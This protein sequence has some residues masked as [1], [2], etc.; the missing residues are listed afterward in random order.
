MGQAL[1]AK[2]CEVAW[3]KIELYKNIIL[4]LGTFHTICNVL[5]IIG[6]RFQ[7]E[8]L[9]DVC[10]E[11]GILAE[12]SVSSVIEGKMYNRAVRIYKYIYEA[13]MRL[14]WKQFIKWLTA[15]NADK[16]RELRVLLSKVNDMVDEAEPEQC[17]SI[18]NS[19]CFKEIYPLWMQYLQYL[20]S[21]NGPL[22]CFWMSYIDIVGDILLGLIRASREGNWQ[23]HLQ[24]IRKMIPWCFAYD[25]IS[26]ATYLPVYYAQMA[27]LPSEH[28]DVYSNFMAGYFSVQL[29][30]K[31]PFGCIPVDQ[32][33]E[34]TVNKDTKSS[35]GITKYSL[36]AGAVT[37]FYLTAEYGCSFLA[38]LRAM[39]QV[40]RPSYHHDEMLS[41]RKTQRRASSN[42]SRESD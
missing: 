38:H 20:R 12:G 14:I 2:A 29:A 4:R 19:D 10:I 28:P 5:S 15:D 17:E 40:K 9:R 7:D 41:T 8:G 36:K 16:V 31:S 39:V 33:T 11:S 21:E 32:T 34:V 3:K 30:G 6:K 13:L 42:S 27:N 24:A 18:L 37:R 25:K 26:Y 22:S 1:Y 23:L 35:G